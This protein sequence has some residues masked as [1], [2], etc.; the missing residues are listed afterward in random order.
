MEE[1]DF[2]MKSTKIGKINFYLFG[3]LIIYCTIFSAFHFSVFSFILHPVSCFFEDF[4]Y[5][6]Y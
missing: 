2:F 6:H 5:I 3:L 4:S 1:D